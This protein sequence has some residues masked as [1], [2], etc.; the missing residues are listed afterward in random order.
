MEFPSY[1]GG[2]GLE[3][4]GLLWCWL[5]YLSNGMGEVLSYVGGGFGFGCMSL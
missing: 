1:C 4:F 5:C 2:V 3:I